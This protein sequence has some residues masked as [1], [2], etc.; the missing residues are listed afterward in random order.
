MLLVIDCG[1][2]N[3]LFALYDRDESCLAQWRTVT[4]TERTADE[5]IVWLLQ[6]F[7]LKKISV[8]DIQDCIISTVVPQALFHLKQLSEE[9]LKISPLIVGDSNV[10]LGIQIKLKNAQ[11]IGSDRLVN[12]IGARKCY[13]GALL[14]VD[15]GTATT[16]DLISS[17]FEFIGGV[18]APGIHL[19]AEALHNAAARLPRIGV[20]KPNS[21]IGKNTNDAMTS[22]IFWG[23]AS[24]I[25]GLISK[26]KAAYSEELSVIATGGIIPLFEQTISQIDHYDTE[27]T[28]RGLL[29][30]W[31]DNRNY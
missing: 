14:I 30:I 15:S 10:K 17:N 19:S 7:S 27:L 1:N 31:K 23:H 11:E 22:G 25:E 5:H 12:A 4:N 13:F 18:I 21:V 29:E 16:F 3:T 6:L 24:L 20:T 9:Y 26:I 8:S 2:T 28:C